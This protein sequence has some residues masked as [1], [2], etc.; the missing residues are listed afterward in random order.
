MNVSPSSKPTRKRPSLR[1]VTL[2]ISF[3]VI[4]GSLGHLSGLADANTS[5]SLAIAAFTG[6]FLVD[7]GLTFRER[8]VPT[9]AALVGLGLVS[10]LLTTFFA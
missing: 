1:G 3:G 5:T 10:Q 7:L 2:A 8:P 4:A 6:A 9:M